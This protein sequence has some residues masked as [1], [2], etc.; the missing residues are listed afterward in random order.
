VPAPQDANSFPGLQAPR[1]ANF[2]V[3]PTNPPSWFKT[4]HKTLSPKD[5]ALIDR[6]FR[7][8]V[9]DVQSVDRMI[10]NV[11]T[12]L[13]DAGVADNTILV[14]S[15]DNG[16][17]LGEYGLL[18]GKKTAFETDVKVPLVV[19]GPGVPAGRV[20]TAPVE[21]ID[22][23]PTFD[24]LAG[25]DA[26]ADIDGHS[27]ADLLYGGQPADWRTAALI[28]HHGGAEDP[29]DPDSGPPA[30]GNPPTYNA[31]RTLEFTYVEYITGD[32]E[33]YDRVSDPYELHNIAGQ[34]STARLGALHSAFST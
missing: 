21:N 12:A 7:L 18:S 8:R 28:E 33:Y 17:H 30:G 10:G 9:Q 4:T 22:L 3:R 2:D 5:Q 15:S 24:N 25:A 6:N 34:L 29:N 11:Q 20:V 1:V 32:R 13:Q 14:F 16:F 19:T 31:L 23:A 27:F 26:P